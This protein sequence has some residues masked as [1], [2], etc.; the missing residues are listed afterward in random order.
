MISTTPDYKR[1]KQI[2]LSTL[3]GA[4]LA[5]GVVDAAMQLQTSS[6]LTLLGSLAM[7]VIGF[8]WLTLDSAELDIRRPMWLNVGI[9]M[10]AAIFVPYY[11]YKTRPAGR[12]LPAIAGF[13]A[14][15]LACAFAS[16]IGAAS[17][18]YFSGT[19]T[20]SGSS[21]PA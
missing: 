16:A 13:F 4:S 14:L 2:A 11:L 6:G 1:Q 19:E 12:R 9:V 7:L 15:I 3:I 8:R 10:A 20:S 5:L 17:M 21:T 18:A